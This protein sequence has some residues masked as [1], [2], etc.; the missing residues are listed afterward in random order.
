MSSCPHC[1]GTSGLYYEATHQYAQYFAWDG[2]NL[3]PSEP[4]GTQSRTARCVDCKKP[5]TKYAKRIKPY[6]IYRWSEK[7]YDMG[8]SIL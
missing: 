8:D 6:N 5:V 7:T 1:G 3:G 2:L 4:E